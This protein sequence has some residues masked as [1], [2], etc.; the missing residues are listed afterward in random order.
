MVPV[1]FGFVFAVKLDCRTAADCLSIPPRATGR[2]GAAIQNQMT[3]SGMHLIVDN[4]ATHK[5]AK[6]RVWLRKHPLFSVY[7]TPTGASWLNM[8]ERFFRDL[9]VRR[10]RAGVF[11][12]VPELETAISQYIE[13][14][15]QS[16][17][18]F[19]W[20]GKAQDILAKVSRVQS[21]MNKTRKLNAHYT[22]SLVECGPPG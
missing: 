13:A 12:S 11:R 2:G 6:V 14:H 8:V 1:R 5:H 17:K 18:P 19:I 3:A 7:Y 4:Y 9:T 15:N 21:A 16:P 22:M 20:T 10:V